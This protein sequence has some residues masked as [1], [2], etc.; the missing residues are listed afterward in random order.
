M[1]LYIETWVELHFIK[2]IYTPSVHL[3]TCFPYFQLYAYRPMNMPYDKWTEPN[4]SKH[5]FNLKYKNSVP[6]SYETQQV[7]II[8]KLPLILFREIFDVYSESHAEHINTLQAWRRLLPSSRQFYPQN[9]LIPPFFLRLPNP[10]LPWGLYFGYWFNN[11]TVLHTSGMC[12]GS[13]FLSFY[14][15]IQ[16]CNF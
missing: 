9:K 5:E 3:S 4:P 2:I 1:F 16:I 13:A 14:N 8:K 15:L 12:V 11:S 10:L 6:N 7:S